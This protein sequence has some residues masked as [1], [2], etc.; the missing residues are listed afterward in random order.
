MERKKERVMKRHNVVLALTLSLFLVIIACPATA[1][2]VP[3]ITANQLKIMIDQGTSVLI[4][5]TQPKLIFDKGHIKGAVSF[6]WKSKITPQDVVGLPRNKPIVTYCSC[7]P[8]EGDSA[9]LAE[10]LINLGFNNVQVL[11]DPS[12]KGWKE[13]GY[14]ME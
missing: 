3:R 1:Q 4:L 14:P 7:G 13:A 9:N 6:P 5:D 8:G 12:I 10:Q 11:A 2:D